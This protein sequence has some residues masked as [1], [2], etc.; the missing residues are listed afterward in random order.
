MPK[1]QGAMIFSD[2]SSLDICVK[3]RE[4]HDDA[5]SILEEEHGDFMLVWALSWSNNPTSTLAVLSSGLS[6]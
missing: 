1:V 2:V 4:K 5:R 3:D 6:Q